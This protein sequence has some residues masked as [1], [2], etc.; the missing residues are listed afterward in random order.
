MSISYFICE[1]VFENLFDWYFLSD[2]KKADFL[3]IE[4]IAAQ[5]PMG[6]STELLF[7]NRNVSSGNHEN[8]VNNCVCS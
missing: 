8:V 6:R 2:F 4:G 3:M 7:V 1:E 5:N